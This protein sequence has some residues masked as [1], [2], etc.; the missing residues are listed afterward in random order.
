[1][2]L[3]G[4]E[5]GEDGE[6]E[7]LLG[8]EGGVGEWGGGEGVEGGEAGLLVEG[9]GVVDFAAD[10]EAVEVGFE[11]VALSLVGDADSELVPDVGAVGEGLGEEDGWG[12]L[13]VAAGAGGGA[14]GGCG[15]REGGG[16]V[17][18]VELGVALAGGGPGVEVGEFYAEEGGLE[19]VYAEVCAD[20]VVVVFG[21]HAVDA[22]DAGAVGEGGV[23]G[24][25]EASV[26]QGAEVFRGEEAEAAEVAEGAE[27]VL[28]VGGAEGLG[29]VFYNREVVLAGEGLEGVH[30]CGL[31]EE[32]DGHDGLG[33]R[34]DAAGGVC[35]VDIE[36]AWAGVYKDGGGAE[37][38]DGACA[39]KEGEAGDE[40]FVSRADAEGHEG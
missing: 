4:G 30:V 19:G 2:D 27:F 1:M 28:A 17:L 32:V 16:E 37:A 10:V 15:L 9:D 25:E 14:G 22:E 40:D 26:S 5:F 20:E 39:G 29:G 13:G 33:A 6:G 23:V 11:G 36:A 21:L 8:E 3:G 38:C 35:G 31:A 34:G 24:G 12:R 18:V 7:D